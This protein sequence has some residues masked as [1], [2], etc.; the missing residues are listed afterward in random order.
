MAK[1][2]YNLKVGSLG[3]KKAQME[4]L[5]TALQG[6]GSKQTANALMN[7]LDSSKFKQMAR[8]GDSAGIA[9]VITQTLMKRA[10]GTAASGARAATG[11]TSL[12]PAQVV[13]NL[14]NI[15][16]TKRLNPA[17]LQ[18]IEGAYQQLDEG[19]SQTAG[20][21][22]RG[23]RQGTM[24]NMPKDTAFA[25]RIA[26]TLQKGKASARSAAGRQGY[27]SSQIMQGLDDLVSKGTQDAGGMHAAGLVDD[28]AL[29]GGVGGVG[30]AAKK[31]ASGAVQGGKG[32]TAPTG[33]MK[34]LQKLGIN[35][36]NAKGIAGGGMKLGTLS[37]MLALLAAAGAGS[38]LEKILHGDPMQHGLRLRELEAM[39]AGMNPQQMYA[40]RMMPVYDQRAAM[41]EQMLAQQMSKGLAKGEE[42]IGGGY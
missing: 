4:Y 19:L 37:G 40:Q 27:Q 33:T 13:A 21:T 5:M 35:P 39:G 11:A 12:N 28:L 14:Y 22:V 23:I 32:L 2:V 18:G 36:S 31:M 6:K 24:P 42:L 7:L 41:A 3:N 34:L 38:S 30:G 9:E 15:A 20:L 8:T 26:E 17:V 25:T 10:G 29:L 16:E 1:Q